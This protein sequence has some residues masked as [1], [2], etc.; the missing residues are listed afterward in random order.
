MKIQRTLPPSAAPLGWAD[1]LRGL[2]APMGSRA[3][4]KRTEE[5]QEHFGVQ[6]VFWVTSGKAALALILSALMRLSSRRKVVI[7]AYTCFSVPSAVM[8]SGL[9]IGLCDV[10]PETLAFNADNLGETLDEDTLA[11]VP[12]HLFGLAVDVEHVKQYARKH[13]I[14]VIE[15]VAQ[16]FGGMRDGKLL[17]TMGDVAFLSFGRGKNVTCGSGGVVL[18]NDP[19]IGNAI[20]WVYDRLST[21]TAVDAFGNWMQV[22]AMRLLLHPRLYWI[23]AGLPFLKL[24]ETKFYT[25]FPVRRMDSMR[26]GLLAG[27]KA[28]LQ[29]ATQVRRERAQTFLHRLQKDVAEYVPLHGSNEAVYLRLPVCAFNRDEKKLLCALS[30]QQ[31]L[32]ISPSYPGTIQDIP[33]LQG[34][35]SCERS[36]GAA[37][38]VECLMTF[39][40]HDLVT[41]HDIERICT[42]AQGILNERDRKE[43][44]DPTE[45]KQRLMAPSHTRRIGLQK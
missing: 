1:I 25:D 29:R 45:E 28:R 18:T 42:A 41:E 7:P 38:L 23:P 26:A 24:G 32:G 9:K 31:G 21:E 6:Y 4:E 12:T 10:E 3:L 11:V 43:I 13:G 14:Y 34:E 22:V 16:G 33:E 39:P 20:Q 5:F 2:V 19:N 15:D 44:T 40:T 8:K 35:L 30:R 37:R 17:G 36:P 27:W